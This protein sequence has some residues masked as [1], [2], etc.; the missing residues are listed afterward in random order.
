MYVLQQCN[1]LV[2]QEEGL[3]YVFE[4]VQSYSHADHLV[5]HYD[6]ESINPRVQLR[7]DDP[8][9]RGE[10]TSLY[11]DQLKN[12]IEGYE[13]L[14]GDE[15]P[16]AWSSTIADRNKSKQRQRQK[17]PLT[18]TIKR[19]Q[20]LFPS[21]SDSAKYSNWKATQT[22]LKGGTN[23]QHPHCDNGIVN[24]YAA[25][26]V[27]PFVCLHAFGVSE[28]KVWL[29]PNPLARSY[30]FEHT[31]APKNMLIMRGDFVHAG[32]PGTSPR[33]HFEFFP[34]ETAGWARKRSFWNQRGNNIVP[35]FLWQHPTYPF[36]FPNVADPDEQGWVVITYP[37]SMT[38]LLRIPMSK[39]QCDTEGVLYIPEAN[40]TRHDRRALCAKI[41]SQS[42]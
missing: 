27:F 24:T 18:T 2:D 10:Y 21:L 26:D 23:I 40:R 3:E 32:G 36:G 33:G 39:K 12:I 35:T 34:R 28:F 5:P 31:F 20:G 14:A 9:T 22:I 4:G 15:E 7:T 8:N 30:G 29:L 41:Q 42:W 38:R 19:V 13:V 6:E 16:I 37:P 11:E 25:L 17:A 1:E